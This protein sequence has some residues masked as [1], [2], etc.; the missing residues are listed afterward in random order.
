MAKDPDTA[1]VKKQWD[2]YHKQKQCGKAAALVKCVAGGVWPN[3][4]KHK[5]GLCQ[6]P[7]CQWCR[8]SE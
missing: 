7:Q 8:D 2:V 1:A 4:R 5:A 6:S 3:E